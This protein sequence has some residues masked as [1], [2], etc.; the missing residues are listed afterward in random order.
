MGTIFPRPHK[1]AKFAHKLGPFA[2]NNCFV[3]HKDAFQNNESLGTRGGSPLYPPKTNSWFQKASP[4][5]LFSFVHS[6][7]NLRIIPWSR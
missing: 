2:S 1:E 7:L 4:R 5:D 3:N 6:P